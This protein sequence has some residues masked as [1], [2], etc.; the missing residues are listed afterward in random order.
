MFPLPNATA[1]LGKNPWAS[2]EGPA[3]AVRPPFFLQLLFQGHRDVP[4]LPVSSLITTSPSSS[5]PPL[6]ASSHPH[7]SLWQRLLLPAQAEV[8]RLVVI[9]PEIFLTNHH[10]LFETELCG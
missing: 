3:P 7:V 10:L 4:C 2:R 8:A 1:P 5:F 6:M 9:R